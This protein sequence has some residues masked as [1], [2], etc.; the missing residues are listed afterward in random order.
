[1]PANNPLRQAIRW[2]LAPEQNYLRWAIALSLSVHAAFLVMRVPS[3]PHATDV[4][5][6]LDVVLVNTVTEQAPLAPKLIAQDDLE[7]GGTQPEPRVAATPE[8][9]VGELAQDISL[10][11]L[12]QQ[13]QDLEAQQ[14]QL[15][16]QL[17][18][19]WQAKPNQ[20]PKQA[21]DPQK[22]PG[23][24]ETDQT[25]LEQNARIAA[26]LEQIDQYN[27]RPRKFF[28]APSAIANPF[29]EYV[30]AWRLRIEEV[31]SAHYPSS[32]DDRPSGSLQ[33]TV[34]IDATGKVID[35]TI[36]EPSKD[37][38]INQSV[39]RIIELA[40]PFAPFPKSLA[41]QADQLVI[42]RT[43]NFTPGTLETK[44]P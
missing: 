25:E 9:R 10:E 44:A 18:S 39:R 33:A 11:A 35:L 13:R 32:P 14:D 29:A 4:P 28:D 3:V 31:G 6:I 26:I 36:D 38:R 8:P 1:M 24:D 20:T 30:E 17:L 43:W 22:T 23:Q 19:I 7:G 40:Q 41:Q 34:T 5:P 2:L 16:K 12:T 15:L 37:P 27:Q 42:T 21:P